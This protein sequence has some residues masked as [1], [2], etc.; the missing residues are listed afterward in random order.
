MAGRA[1]PQPSRYPLRSLRLRARSSSR[2]TA[3]Q[4]HLALRLVRSDR[5]ALIVN[6]LNPGTI[7]SMIRSHTAIALVLGALSTAAV[8]GT[9]RLEWQPQQSGVTAR[10]R[11]IS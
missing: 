11:G 1:V 10:L 7:R 2:R 6:R 8:D 9:T 4:R 3:P 5:V